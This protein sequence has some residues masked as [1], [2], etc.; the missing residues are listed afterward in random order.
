MDMVAFLSFLSQ[1]VVSDMTHHFLFIPLTFVQIV[2]TSFVSRAA[3]RNDNASLKVHTLEMLM[4]YNENE[5]ACMLMWRQE[6]SYSPAVFCWFCFFLPRLSHQKSPFLCLKCKTNIF[7][8]KG[9]SKQTIIGFLFSCPLPTP[10]HTEVLLNRIIKNHITECFHKW[11]IISNVQI[12]APKEI[13]KI[14]FTSV[15]NFNVI[16]RMKPADIWGPMQI[17]KA[18][19]LNKDLV[20]RVGTEEKQLKPFGENNNE[21]WGERGHF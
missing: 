9:V 17:C 4:A 7:S 2:R 18:L 20:E 10:K 1:P 14:H 15:Q 8:I 3:F 13:N 12:I 5:I 11:N 6:K 16:F 19:Y 21:V